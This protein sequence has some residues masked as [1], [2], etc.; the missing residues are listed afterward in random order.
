MGSTPV[1][2]ILKCMHEDFPVSRVSPLWEGSEYNN[3][4]DAAKKK[5][6]I[7]HAAFKTNK[8]KKTLERAALCDILEIKLKVAPVTHR[9]VRI[10]ALDGM[11]MGATTAFLDRFPTAEIWICN[12]DAPSMMPAYSRLS[13]NDKK[14][15]HIFGCMVEEF[16]AECYRWLDHELVFD[17]IW[18]DLVKCVNRDFKM[19]LFH[20]I[21]SDVLVHPWNRKVLG[22]DLGILAVDV[23]ERKSLGPM[24]GATRLEVATCVAATARSMDKITLP[25]QSLAQ[26]V[27]SGGGGFPLQIFILQD[28]FNQEGRKT[29]EIFASRINVCMRERH[30]NDKR[31]SVGYNMLYSEAESTSNSSSSA[32][33]V[34][35]TVV[36][37]PKRGRKER[38]VVVRNV[39]PLIATVGD[40][41][42]QIDFGDDTHENY[43]FYIWLFTRLDL[44]DGCTLAHY[45][46]V[47]SDRIIA[48]PKVPHKKRPRPEA[49]YFHLTGRD[50]ISG[51]TYRLHANAECAGIKC[52]MTKRKKGGQKKL[53]VERY[54]GD[55]HNNNRSAVVYCGL[56]CCKTKGQ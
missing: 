33:N 35:I 55:E 29:E 42:R 43:T 3:K 26:P 21:A 34:D 12:P 39:D 54:D 14:R 15:V 37:K 49:T 4:R 23:C 22:T 40:I 30:V 31:V 5:K 48:I 51:Y 52:S 16:A 6:P 46:I 1:S 18:L 41:K 11:N 7:K 44:H 20:F 24:A 38:S 27:V 2:M 47:A 36:I 13:T 32:N 17:L 50:E 45:G 28:R 53:K 9:P 25:I 56:C 10:L 8:K 19:M